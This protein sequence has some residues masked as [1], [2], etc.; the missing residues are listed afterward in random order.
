[1]SRFSSGDA[2]KGKSALLAGGCR[3]GKLWLALRASL[4]GLALP[5]LLRLLPLPSLLRLLTPRVRARKGSPESPASRAA[6]VMAVLSRL[7]PLRSRPCL[8]RS[9]LLYK[10]LREAGLPVR[11]HFGVNRR[12][13]GGGL[14]GHSWLTLDGRPFLER[15]ELQGRFATV[16]SYPPDEGGE[17]GR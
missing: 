13:A 8:Y 5:A 1:M 7:P 17:A 14:V 11:I 6:V 3:L 12:E 16:F 15:E 9:L 2:A 10:F 4:W